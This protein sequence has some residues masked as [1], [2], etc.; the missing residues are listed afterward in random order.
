MSRGA[1][2]HLCEP[3][4]CNYTTNNEFS[5]SSERVSINISR[6]KVW[7]NLKNEGLE[8]KC[9]MIAYYKYDGMTALDLPIGWKRRQ[10][11]KPNPVQL[12]FLTLCTLRTTR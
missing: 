2:V 4:A 1:S 12:V 8:R 3:E 6:V 11:I 5:M 10:S 7:Y 9:V